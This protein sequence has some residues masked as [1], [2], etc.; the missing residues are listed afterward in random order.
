VAANLQND[1]SIVAST[2]A[3]MLGSRRTS[4][5]AHLGR[6]AAA[7]AGTVLVALLVHGLGPA[8]IAA[9]L[10][11]VRAR[12]LWLLGAYLVANLAYAIPFGVVLPRAARP[13]L[14][15]LFAS[16]LAA[17]S[18]NAAT[19]FLGVGGEPVRL[20]W[21]PPGARRPGIAALVVDR[22]AFLAGSA[23]FLCGGALA[24][25]RIALP[26]TVKALLLVV[27][28]TSL[29]LVIAL[30]AIQRRGGVAAPVARLAGLLVRRRRAALAAHAASIDAEVRELH[31]VRPARFAGAV[32]LHLLG[33]CL[34]ALE[35]LGGVRLLGIGIGLEG[36]FVLAS[37]PLIVDLAFSIVPSQIGIYEGTNALL[38]GALGVDP[39][40]GVA[41]AFLQRLRQVVFLSA[42]FTLIALRRPRAARPHSGDE[43]I[44]D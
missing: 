38:A 8:R 24:A 23:L 10:R 9:Q 13:S 6:I 29:G 17:L 31:L 25:L 35:V 26:P 16:R 7:V 37:V 30:C 4:R 39:A 5:L 1:R 21:L 19:P 27:G 36:S 18:V 14:P 44:Q 20:L 11:Q 41:L 33:R 3:D 22:S 2:T 32:G 12:F 43:M 34:A 15:S 40:A 42:G 28:A